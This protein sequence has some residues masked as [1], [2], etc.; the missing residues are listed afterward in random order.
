[1]AEEEQ[2]IRTRDWYLRHAERDELFAKPDD[3]WEIN[4][5]ADRGGEVP[6][7]M[8]EALQQSAEVALTGKFGELQ[9]ISPELDGPF[10]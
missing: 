6:Q 5:V 8:V 1:V 10:A 9:P 7:L 2:G 4:E 3:R